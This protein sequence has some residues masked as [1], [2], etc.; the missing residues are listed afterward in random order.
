ME[1]VERYHSAEVTQVQ[2]STN[3]SIQ[4]TEEINS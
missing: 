3:I 1:A 4:H 2:I